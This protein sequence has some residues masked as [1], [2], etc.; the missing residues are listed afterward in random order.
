MRATQTVEPGVSLWQR[1]A[2]AWTSGH[3]NGE[4]PFVE[5][6][7]APSLRMPTAPRRKDRL[8]SLRRAVLAATLSMSSSEKEGMVLQGEFDDGCVAGVCDDEAE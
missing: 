3:G 5:D 8:S 7:M 1:R 6:T 4:G 2:S